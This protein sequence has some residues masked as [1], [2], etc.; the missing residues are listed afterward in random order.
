MG[1]PSS[2]PLPRSA[3]ATDIIRFYSRKLLVAA[4]AIISFTVLFLLY[5]R[6][7]SLNLN[8][9]SHRPQPISPSEAP[10]NKP[11]SPFHPHS[12]DNFIHLDAIKEFWAPWASAILASKPPI[13][14]ITVR[15]PHSNLGV[16]EEEARKPRTPPANLINLSPSEMSNLT[17][18][19]A[20]FMGNLA[21][22]KYPDRD[23]NSLFHH[24]GVVTV[25]GGE[26][27]GPAIVG[28]HMLRASGCDLAVEAFVQNWD[29]YE[30]ELCEEYLPKLN[31]RCLVIEDFL[32]AHVDKALEVTH[33]QLKSLA[34]LFSSFRDVLLLDSDSIPLVDPAK[35]FQSAAYKTTGFVGWSDFWKSSE[36]PSFWTIA[37]LPSFP[38]NLPS[39][40]SESGQIVV[41]KMR[42]LKTLLLA[43]Y[44]NIWGPKWFY[45]LLSQG[46]LG[47]GDKNTFETAAVV[48]NSPFSR[49]PKG[50]KSVSRRTGE[51]GAVKGSA[52]LQFMPENI[53][54]D[55][56]N[57]G[58]EVIPTSDRPA[59]IH[60]NTP[61]MNAGHLVDE[62]DL[63]TDEG[64]HLRLW[65]SKEDQVKIFGEDLEKRVWLIVKETGCELANVVKEWK[66][67]KHLCKRL[68][69]HW[70]EVFG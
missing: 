65:G 56:M 69:E 25:A 12:H 37:G 70:N 63:V 60:A 41:D 29:E 34:L 38:A 51:R 58:L 68:K 9:G 7:S 1:S 57:E 36:T 31:A 67:R 54:P 14:E 4:A 47:Q 21:A 43:T 52:M 42:H 13:P 24:R 61:K 2:G 44:Y 35:L 20:S 17:E 49:V 30:P 18:A 19:H 59:F 5:T 3:R 39:P 55:G 40:C 62:G 27:F 22:Y 23:V 26:Y 32:S 46:A 28:I 48:L 15:M 11:P 64:R 10:D 53:L 33:Y 66:D 45:P 8:Y 16:S 6:G 50:V